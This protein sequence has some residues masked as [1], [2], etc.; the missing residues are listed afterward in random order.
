MGDNIEAGNRSDLDTAMTFYAPDALWET[1]PMGLG[2]YEG[3]AAI[4]AFF[5]DWLAAYE[6]FEI[7]PEE[8]R[9]PRQRSRARRDPSGCPS[10]GQPGRVQ[11]RYAAVAVWVER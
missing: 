9:R 8:I 2:V 5:E 10:G 6:E 7:E 3:A 1:S 4:R 11:V